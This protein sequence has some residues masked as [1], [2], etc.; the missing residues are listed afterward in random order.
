[1]FLIFYLYLSI[2]NMLHATYQTFFCNSKRSYSS[3]CTIMLQY[4]YRSRHYAYACLMIK[5][6]ECSKNALTLN[7]ESRNICL[8][9]L[10]PLRP[11]SQHNWWRPN[12][13][14]IY[15]NLHLNLCSFLSIVIELDLYIYHTYF[16]ELNTDFQ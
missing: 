14:R 13:V 5:N 3:H 2:W 11:K 9:F 15:A 16:T 4:Q 12:T 1:M 8:H 6:A 10:R 7:G